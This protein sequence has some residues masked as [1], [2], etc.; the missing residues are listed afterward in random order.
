MSSKRTQLLKHK[1]GELIKPV[2]SAHGKSK[3]SRN[4]ALYFGMD[5]PQ[6]ES[7][8]IPIWVRDGWGTDEKS[9]ITDARASGLDSPVIHVF[10][11]KLRADVLA[12]A[13]ASS[14]AAQETLDFMGVP[15][16][17]EG[18]E[19]RKGLETRLNEAKKQSHALIVEAINSAKVYQGGG[20]ERLEDSLPDK[21]KEAGNASIERLFPDFGEADDA[22]WHKVI[23]RARGGAANPL[24]VL[25]YNGKPEDHPVCKAVLSLIG[26]GMKGRRIRGHFSAPPYGWSRDAIDGAILV[27]FGNGH[28]QAA[29]N[30]KP[31]K[32]GNLDQSSIPKTYF[33]VESVTINTHDRLRI[34]K[35][36]TDARISCKPNE[37]NIAAGEFLNKL[38]ALAANAGGDAPLPPRPDTRLI[39]ELRSLTGNEQLAAILENYDELSQCHSDWTN[40]QNSARDRRPAYHRLQSLAHHATGLTVYQE[41]K[42]QIDAIVANRS[43]LETTD[44]IPDLSKILTDALRTALVKAEQIHSE[45]FKQEMGK[46]EAAESWQGIN[47]ID[48]NQILWRLGITKA[49]KSSTGTEKDVLDSLDRVSL[50]SWRTRSAALRNL[51]EKAQIQAAKLLEP[52]T[53][54]VRLP[55]ATL[56]SPEEIREWVERAEEELLEHLKRGPIMIV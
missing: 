51:F 19:A 15:V 32:P 40:L 56:S 20:N 30:G 33:K 48:R 10:I 35:L 5:P 24:E 13:I 42:P 7:H 2:R 11:P 36:I 43:L 1:C 8:E 22:R 6:S 3:V 4:L 34:R 45:I 49:S 46:L 44:P 28:L 39:N 27:L 21:I 52:K 25:N 14:N 37:E 23:Q 55:P 53:H 38:R 54:P 50:Q 41:V 47:Q 26:S 12:H 18:V 31:L 17:P 16:T 29:H 9:V